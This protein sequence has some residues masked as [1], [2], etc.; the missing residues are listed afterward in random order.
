[1]G[2]VVVGLGRVARARPPLLQSLLPQTRRRPDCLPRVVHKLLHPRL[3]GPRDRVLLEE[4]KARLLCRLLRLDV[5]G[6]VV[7][8][9][10]SRAATT[11]FNLSQ[12]A[13]ELVGSCT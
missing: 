4:R 11:K 1:V 2:G 8:R 9:L 13:Y 10:R 5:I 6:M 7:S 3:L 12:V